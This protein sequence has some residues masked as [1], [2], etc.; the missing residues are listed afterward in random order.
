[1][2]W[3]PLW[4]TALVNVTQ[5]TWFWHRLQPLTGSPITVTA[6][7]TVPDPAPG[8][9]AVFRL[10]EFANYGGNAAQRLF[11]PGQ[12][13]DLTPGVAPADPLMEPAGNTSITAEPSHHT[14]VTLNQ[15]VILDQTWG[16][17]WTRE[18]TST[19]PAN[20]LLSGLNNVQVGA[21]VTP[22]NVTDWVF[23]NYWEVDY[24]R[25]FHAWQGQFDFRAEVTGPHEYV[26]G[27]WT[28]KW[29]AI[30]DI[31]NA[32]QPRQLTGALPGLEGAGTTQLRF[33]TTDSVGSRYWPAGGSGLRPPGLAPHPPPYRPARPC[34]WRGRRHRHTSSVCPAATTLAAWHEQHGRRAVVVPLQDIYDEFN[35]GIQIAPEA[36][37]N[38]LRWAVSHWPAPAPAYSDPPRRWP[39]EHEG[40]QPRGLRHGS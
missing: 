38:L 3:F 21:W 25:L 34:P 1:M 8:V 23:V 5:D 37:P 24:R 10:M 7:Y 39:L 31:S 15:A 18:L 19:I 32:D 22:G 35:E 33:R 12:A 40:F 30:W 36:I 9:G 26:V 6:S 17:R 29:V 16:G 28:T 20:G 14:I 4:T 2:S 11:V 13:P 27:N